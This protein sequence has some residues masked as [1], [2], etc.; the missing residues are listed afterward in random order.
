MSSSGDLAGLRVVVTRAPHQAGALSDRLAERGAIVIEAPVIA[1]LPPDDPAPLGEV[2]RRAGE[3]DALIIGSANAI[4]AVASR[5]LPI[6]VPVVVVGQKTGALASRTPAVFR[7]PI[8]V[9]ERSSAEGMVDAIRI[10]FHPVRGRRFA[11]LRAPEGREA[12]IDLLAMDGARVDAVAA[13]R[14]APATL[15][16]EVLARLSEADVFTFLSGET[17]AAFLAGVPDGLR[18]LAAGRVA[19]IGPIAGARAEA[20]GVRVDIMPGETTAEALVEAI[21]RDNLSRQGTA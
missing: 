10:R 20:L 13:Y 21:A 9:A 1:V 6:D 2:L 8:I 4:A 7:G 18:L 19:V 3:Y 17:L 15:E 11:F 12:A 5:G 14:V 16:P